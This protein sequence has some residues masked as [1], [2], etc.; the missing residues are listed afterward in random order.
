MILG[1]MNSKIHDFQKST[2]TPFELKS[3]VLAKASILS[4]PLDSDRM[5]D[6]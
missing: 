4:S 6:G 5:R 2:P 1:N 3:F